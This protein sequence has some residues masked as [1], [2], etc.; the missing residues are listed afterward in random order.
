MVEARPY[1]E[2]RTAR[3]L[4][5]VPVVALLAIVAGYIAMVAG[6]GGPGP[7]DVLTVPFV[8]AYLLLM[9]AI[10]AVSSAVADDLTAL[11][12]DRRRIVVTP[13]G[14]TP[15]PA[16]PSGSPAPSVGYLLTVHPSRG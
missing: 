3:V 12:V 9:A 4:V 14:L 13:L 7:S 16:P 2:G 1:S 10:L 6:Q 8:A 5:A 11:G 15:L